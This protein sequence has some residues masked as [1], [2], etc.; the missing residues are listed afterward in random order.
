MIKDRQKKLSQKII[1]VSNII[2]NRHSNGDYV[3]ANSY[4]IE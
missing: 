4:V 3:I 2:N 1:T